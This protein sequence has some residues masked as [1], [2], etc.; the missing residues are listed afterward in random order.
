MTISLIQFIVSNYDILF[1][2]ALLVLFL[3][4]SD[5]ITAKMRANFCVLAGM[6]LAESV[7]SSL[8]LQMAMQAGVY[9]P[10]RFVCS[11]CCY[12]LKPAVE[13]GIVIMMVR[14]D[15]RTIGKVLLGLPL[16]AMTVMLL[17]NPWTKFVFFITED[18]I[19]DSGSFGWVTSFTAA[20]YLVELFVVGLMRWKKH[21]W[22]SIDVFLILVFVVGGML[23]IRK[24]WKNNLQEVTLSLAVLGYFMY[25]QSKRHGD[26]LA[27]AQL[28]MAQTRQ[29]TTAHMLNESI[30]TLSGTIDAKDRYTRGHSARVA[31]YSKRIAELAGMEPELCERVYHAG[32]LHDIG[33]IGIPGDIIN[34]PG[35]LT[36]EEY[37]IIKSHPKRGSEILA[38]MGDMPYLAEGA[39]YH[40]ERFDGRG[41]PTGL[42]GYDIPT[43]GRIIA[44]ADAYDAMTSDRSY[45]H[46][47]PQAVVR[48]QIYVGSG[49][50]F[51]PQYAEIMLRMIDEDTD[52]RM[53]EI[54]EDSQD[55][56]LDGEFDIQAFR[57]AHTP[58][59]RVTEH[60]VTVTL[61]V[62][63]SADAMTSAAAGT[64]GTVQPTAPDTGTVQPA[65]GTV[66]PTAPGTGTAQPTVILF[67][68]EDGMVAFN[69][70]GQCTGRNHYREFAGIRCDGHTWT[71]QAKRLE[72]GITAQSESAATAGI[73]SADT[74]SAATAVTTTSSADTMTVTAS[75]LDNNVNLTICYD[76]RT[77]NAAV[78]LP[79]SYSWLYLALTGERVVLS[80]IEVDYA[81]QEIKEEEFTR[82]DR[83]ASP[84]EDKRTGDMPN[85]DCSSLYSAY[86]SGVN[87]GSRRICLRYEVGTYPE[88]NRIW[89]SAIVVLYTSADGRV[90]GEGYRKL[91]TLRSNGEG[92]VSDSETRADT[93]KRLSDSFGGWEQWLK[94]N[95]LGAKCTMTAVR[96]GS[97]LFLTNLNQGVDLKSEIMLPF[98]DDVPVYVALTGE[99]CTISDIHLSAQ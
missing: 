92:R 2:M 99:L 34:K 81:E 66:Q 8:E 12:I 95:K 77:I 1:I 20:F 94:G 51:D 59:I 42:S 97:R 70:E 14:D 85:I 63:S 45:R 36:D 5:N 98:G 28:E 46:Y 25:F 67:D 3:F 26:A 29:K 60:P 17:I 47:M 50:Q 56:R 18:N 27:Q 43:L 86:T 89:H 49:S 19:F 48:E 78:A 32:L 31:A 88:A 72:S 41:Y 39:L 73:G 61:K 35:R 9:S 23:I 68:S 62:H 83:A 44:V 40:H 52:Y 71:D 64:A 53:H 4:Q 24:S 21:K 6:V 65:A 91:Y 82:I 22:E 80:Q 76:G 90:N 55:R 33:K 7:L 75:K 10:W 57:T 37:N 93:Q 74:A 13:F 69:A 87:V 54:A 96:Q 84:L 58:G 11:T 79:D 38:G 15:H 30:E 16:V